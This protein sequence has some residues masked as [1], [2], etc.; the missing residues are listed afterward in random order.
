MVHRAGIGTCARHWLSSSQGQGKDA[1]GISSS[2][3]SSSCSAGRPPPN[4]IP[5]TRVGTAAGRCVA[6]AT[7]QQGCSTTEHTV[8]ARLLATL[9]ARGTSSLPPAHPCECVLLHPGALLK[10]VDAQRGGLQA[11]RAHESVDG[12]AVDGLVLLLLLQRRRRGTTCAASRS[13]VQQAL[14][15]SS[16]AVRGWAALH[17]HVRRRCTPAAVSATPLQSHTSAHL[18][19]TTHHEAAHPVRPGHGSHCTWPAARRRW[20]P[21]AGC[22][23]HQ[24]ARSAG[25]TVPP[26]PHQG[27]GQPSSPGAGGSWWCPSGRRPAARRA[28]C[29]R[30]GRD[31]GGGPPLPA[32]RR[33]PPGATCKTVQDARRRGVGTRGPTGSSSGAGFNKDAPVGASARGQPPANWNS[34]RLQARVGRRRAPRGRRSI[35]TRA[36]LT[37]ARDCCASSCSFICCSAATSEVVRSSTPLPRPLCTSLLPHPPAVLSRAI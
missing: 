4:A 34:G 28:G 31:G 12:A 36:H 5:A 10:V 29:G 11:S 13:K 6:V 7:L 30:A 32:A 17:P 25:P 23:A 1:P 18:S 8:P 16:R 14:Q 22:A 19:A 26:A 9:Q 27:P 37:G 3:S 35:L 20:A 33:A 15:A 24:T 2:P 21:G